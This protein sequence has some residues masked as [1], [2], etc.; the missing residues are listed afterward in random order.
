MKILDVKVMRGPNYWSTYRKQ[1]IVMKLDLEELEQYPTNKIDGFPARLREMIPSLYEHRCSEEEKGGFF[2]RVDEGTWMGHVVEHIALEL[3]S[4]AGM[5]CG[6]GRTRSAER[7]GVYH[8]VFSYEVEEAG[9]YA[10]HAAVRVADALVKGEAYDVGEDI[11]ML[12][13]IH[14]RDGFGPSTLS[15]VNEA[16]RRNIPYKRLDNSSLVL[17]GQGVNQRKIRASMTGATSS[18]GVEMACDKEETKRILSKAFIPM[19]KGDIAADEEDLKDIIDRIG[20]PLVIKPVDGNHG[21]GVTTNINSVEHAMNAL[22]IAQ[23]I[24]RDVI[25]E[26]FVE[27]SDYRFLVINFK[28]VAAARRTPAS[29][30]G[31]G[32]SSIAKL[33][34]LVNSD[35][36]RG[37]GHEKVLTAIK[38]DDITKGIL[39][40]KNYTLDTVLPAGEVLY[41]KDSANLS[42]GGVSRDVTDIVHPHNVFLAERIARILNLDVCGIDIVA[43][44][45]NI[46]ITDNVGAVIE[47]NASPG[48]RMHLSP[49]KGL[50]RNVAEPMMDMLYPPGTPS[51]IPLVAV[52]GTNGKTT[53]TRLIAHLAKSAGHQVGYTTTD[54]IYIGDQKIT[55]GDCSGPRSAEAVLMDP[56]VDFAVLECARGGI[57]R[58]GLGFDQCDI[59]ILTNIS[60][61][62]LGLKDIYTLEDMLDV[63]SV[64]AQSTSEDGY[65]IL[66]ADDDL[67]YSLARK[68]D[69]NVALFSTDENNERIRR[70]CEKGGLAAIIENGYV[71]ICK[72]QWKTRVDKVVHIPLTQEGR[73]SCMIK[74]ILPVVLVGTIR[75][76]GIEAIR[77]ALRSF[78]PSPMHTPG[79]LNVFDF[80]DF[81]V[82]IDYAHNVGGYHELK[83]YLER[84]PATW[85]VGIIGGIGDRRE[86]DNRNA[87]SC[88]AE[89]FDEVIIKC[90]R[91]LRG[92]TEQRLTELLLEGIRRVKPVMKT[93]II[94]NEL[95]ALRHAIENA[96]PGSFIT[97]LTDDVQQSISLVTSMLMDEAR[98]KEDPMNYH[99]QM[100]KAS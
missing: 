73:A 32:R 76:M 46:P 51:R 96:Q 87:G 42:S 23:E 7:E 41:L 36:N 99:R 31:D 62:H 83:Y 50:P 40:S 19:P 85:K 6:Y 95:E 71:T 93:T 60:A 89:M 10:A 2:K 15:I 82:M 35:P 3:Q 94:T 55:S 61:D 29:V 25:V 45:V 20:F 52:T 34:E 97:M 59:S 78:Y 39:A 5:D 48:F 100:S 12:K 11:R 81:Q 63:K 9:T 14:A 77:S 74:N 22:R 86:E 33:I 4:L 21:R 30:T 17:F 54:G 69:C 68:L 18:I 56:T 43:K 47:V 1:V 98:R 75:N 88:A 49:S 37:E 57:L 38:V 65:S 64:V 13:K 53:T 91:D 70:H 16:R 44:D 80:R 27:G 72:G 58:S 8:V 84:T 28:L 24:S 79:R 92:N 26:R 66:N 67:V 90:D